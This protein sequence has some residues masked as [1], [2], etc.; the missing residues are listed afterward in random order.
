M[1]QRSAYALSATRRLL[2]CAAGALLIAAPIGF[3]VLHGQSSPAAAANSPQP[4]E[5]TPDLPKYEVATIK[6]SSEEDGRVRMMLTPDGAELNGV[7]LP[8]LLQQ[9]FGVERD[10]IV[11]VPDWARSRRFDI[12]AKVAPEDAPKLDKLKMEQRRA[13]ILPLLQERFGLKFHHE[14]RELPMYSLVVAKGGPKLKASTTPVSPPP[15]VPA[16]PNGPSSPDQPGRAAGLSRQGPGGPGMMRISPGA[17]EANGGATSFLAH[18]LSNLVGR[19]VVDNTGLTGNYDYNLHWTPDESLMP[20]GGPGDGGP[21]LQADAP[22][23]PNGPT[24]FTA[25]EEQLGLKLES[26]KGKVDVIVIDHID[27]PSEN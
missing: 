11:G 18:A 12:A 22:I 7:Q 14:T 8:M 1:A 27:P 24:L 9:A 5:W 26:Q 2:L 3:G 15:G 16:A 23:D 20:R 17:I 21:H 19:S 4:F 6:P 10:R 25:L 13:M